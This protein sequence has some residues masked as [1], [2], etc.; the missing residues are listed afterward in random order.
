M[1]LKFTPSLRS[2]EPMKFKRPWTPYSFNL[3]FNLFPERDK[4]IM[5]THLSQSEQ[6]HPRQ[7]TCCRS[8]QAVLISYSVTKLPVAV[9]NSRGCPWL[10]K[11]REFQEILSRPAVDRGR[12]VRRDT[13]SCCSVVALVDSISL[14]K[15]LP[16]RLIFMWRIW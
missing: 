16:C 5:K 8:L 10:Y 7:I 2:F 14:L 1:K 9:L 12:L 11:T 15:R 13:A 6:H 3:S 4:L